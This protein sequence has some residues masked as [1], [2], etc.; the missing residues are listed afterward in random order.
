M[1]ARITKKQNPDGSFSYS[2]RNKNG[3]IQTSVK[4]T[5]FSFALVLN[6]TRVISFGNSESGL[7][8]KKREEEKG[9][10]KIGFAAS[11]RI[12]Q[13]LSENEA[14]LQEMKAKEIDK[15]LEDQQ[16][17][18]NEEDYDKAEAIEQKINR[19]SGY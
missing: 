17:A 9:A 12:A 18:I 3:E 13:I 2:V 1:K 11:Y 4:K 16:T 8:S 5:D 15:L 6:E 19:I 10:Q 7:W 14:K